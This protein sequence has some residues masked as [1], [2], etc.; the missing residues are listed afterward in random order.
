MKQNKTLQEL[1]SFPGF[2]AK[3]RLQGKFG[4]PRARIVVLTRQKK[5]L[6]VL[7]VASVT[8]HIMTA[9]NL[10]REILMQQIIEYTC[11][12]NGDGYSV[13]GATVCA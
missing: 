11:A 6:C 4:D 2:K 1:F 9:K 10:K 3:K 5:Q 12:M 7:D 13:H 8:K